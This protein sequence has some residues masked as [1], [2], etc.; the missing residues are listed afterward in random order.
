MKKILTYSLFTLA[1]ISLLIACSKKNDDVK[2]SNIDG[3]YHMYEME[4]YNP[5]ST[6][7]MPAEGYRGEVHVSVKSDSSAALRILL[8]KN[9]SKDV[10]ETVDCWIRPD[11][12]GGIT[13]EEKSTGSRAAYLIEK[14]DIDVYWVPNYRFSAR[15]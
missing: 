1:A 14:N 11:S 2:P 15:K 3:V 9:E 8:F 4:E 13:L 10:D 12:D 7:Q 5:S 6:V